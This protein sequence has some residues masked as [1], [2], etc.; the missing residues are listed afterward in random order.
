MASL[1]IRAI[2][3][4]SAKGFIAAMQG[5][6]GAAQR[7]SGR[8]SG[9][10]R[11]LG[12]SPAIAAIGTLAGSFI[13]LGAAIRTA[14]RF[15]GIE[16]S[17]RVL[18]KDGEA[19]KD[20][21][22]EIRQIAAK[23]PAV[24]EEQGLST[25]R[26]LLAAGFD[27]DESTEGFR[28]LSDLATA[29]RRP[30]ND[31]TFAFAQAKVEGRAFTR[32]LRQFATRGVPI[33]EEL[34]KAQGVSQQ[35]LTKLVEA[36]KIGFPEV[37]EALTNLVAE[38]GRFEGAAEAASKTFDGLI[39]GLK[40]GFTTLVVLFGAPVI[41]A[42][43]PL[44]E[45]ITRTLSDLGPTLSFVSGLLGFAIRL[46]GE[47][48]NA[49]S[50]L[51]STALLPFNVLIR[52]IADFLKGDLGFKGAR[53][54]ADKWASSLGLAA[55]KTDELQDST[56]ALKEQAERA[57]EALKEQRE[58]VEKQIQSFEKLKDIRGQAEED[59]QNF[60]VKRGQLNEGDVL[61]ENLERSRDRIARLNVDLEKLRDN[62]VEQNLGA[63]LALTEAT[64][65]VARLEAELAKVGAQAAVVEDG[66][67]ALREAFE[68]GRD[69]GANPIS[70]NLDELIQL[71]AEADRRLSNVLSAPAESLPPS[72]KFLRDLRD[73]VS[74]L[75][76][77]ATKGNVE[78]LLLRS[79]TGLEQ[80]FKGS[81]FLAQN[82]REALD[83]ID[84]EIKKAFDNPDD[85]SPKIQ[86][87]L[88]AANK[89]LARISSEVT[90]AQQE[91]AKE[92]VR[93]ETEVTRET[94]KREKILER[95]AETREEAA[96]K[97]LKK[98]EDALEKLEEE[99]DLQLKII[100]AEAERARIRGEQQVSSL[101]LAGQDDE[102]NAL[103]QL[104][105]VSA[106][107]TEFRRRGFSLT[108]ATLRAQRAVFQEAAQAAVDKDAAD[109]K[110]L[111]AAR[112]RKGEESRARIDFKA[113]LEIQELRKAGR[114][115][116]AAA[117]ETELKL[118]QRALELQKELG[119]SKELAA[120]YAAREAAA[121]LE[122]L[123]RESRFQRAPLASLRS[124]G[125]GDTIGVALGPSGSQD[126]QKEQ[127]DIQKA[128]LKVISDFNERFNPEE[129]QCVRAS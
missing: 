91:S 51:V 17:F 89:E 126:L 68:E 5:A 3:G 97:A 77:D 86:E 104:L 101:R 63:G 71:E 76:K 14:G 79:G 74:Q 109:R 106:K 58:E 50:K 127:T 107:I 30:I 9:F 124:I 48:A 113:E 102:A 92:I 105:D 103:Q 98:Q 70:K 23:T 43:K 24:T 28:L 120:E 25:V 114:D 31:L 129:I 73:E 38:G 7:A 99:L 37:N 94:L 27:A 1:S 108:E 44:L 78:D 42:L 61:A 123:E 121:N 64:E 18:L 117:L 90:A 26:Q 19:A 81:I 95:I 57:T 11:S 2:I 111:K 6:V 87:D 100:D 16:T 12:F 10:F 60:R 128:I 39:V 8:I 65:S 21:F 53:E 32:D 54:A 82:L 85:R 40:T 55:E 4:G 33:F 56:K 112:E 29:T 115:E 46:L 80:S 75:G 66:V 72:I 52:G 13:A 47:F 67:E 22:N 41:Q 88:L 83:D 119:I 96:E 36:G 35:E 62:D 15:E 49:V 84:A 59:L 93:Q 118:R 116:E 110:S 45:A 20:L 34:A 122:N 69:D 125:G